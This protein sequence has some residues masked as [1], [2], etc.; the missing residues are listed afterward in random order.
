MQIGKAHILIAMILG[1]GLSHTA[2]AQAN[3]NSVRSNKATVAAPNGDPAAPDA[4]S[5]DEAGAAKANIVITPSNTKGAQAPAPDETA[6]ANI[7]TS[8]SNSKGIAAP[9]PDGTADASPANINTSRSNTKGAKAP[10]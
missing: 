1:A 4:A 5:G 2:L 3:H 10:Q 9:V 8:R 7:N 6:P